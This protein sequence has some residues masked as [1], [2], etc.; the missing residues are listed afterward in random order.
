MSRD[1]HVVIY[2]GPGCGPCKAAKAYFS[3][4][5]VTFTEYDV[6]KEPERAS[7]LMELSGSMSIPV[8][9][10]DDTVI[11]GFDKEKINSELGIS[12]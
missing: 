4:Q 3:Q 5:G 7:E 9:V 10:I 8:I 11:Q 1:K 2:S 12:G 6:A